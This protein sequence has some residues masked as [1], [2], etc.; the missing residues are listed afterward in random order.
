M[1]D[2]VNEVPRNVQDAIARNVLKGS[3]WLIVNM[4]VSP[5]VVV[6]RGSFSNADWLDAFQAVKSNAENA[7]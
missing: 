2:A 1:S 4:D 5:P 7:T 3:K 6:K